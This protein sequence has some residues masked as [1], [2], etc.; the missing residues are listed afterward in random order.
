MYVTLDALVAF[1]Q[2]RSFAIRMLAK[3][4][5]LEVMVWTILPPFEGDQAFCLDAVFELYLHFVLHF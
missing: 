2:I 3:E 5:Y 4:Y 1:A